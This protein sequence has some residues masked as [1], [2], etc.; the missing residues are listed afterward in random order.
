MRTLISIC[1]LGLSLFLSRKK[2]NLCLCWFVFAS[3]ITSRVAA[4]CVRLRSCLGGVHD[5]VTAALPRFPDR[6]AHSLSFPS[7]DG[8]FNLHTGPLCRVGNVLNSRRW[9]LVAFLS[10][11]FVHPTLVCLLTNIAIFVAFASVVALARAPA[12]DNDSTYG[13]TKYYFL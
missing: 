4:G 5:R 9:F 7:F 1:L 2:E 11:R 3:R 12:R 8:S 6:R 13:K 10:A